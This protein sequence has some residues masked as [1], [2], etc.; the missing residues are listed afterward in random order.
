MQGRVTAGKTQLEERLLCTE[1]TV[2]GLGKLF[3][4]RVISGDKDSVVVQAE[5]CQGLSLGVAN[6]VFLLDYGH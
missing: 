2:G 1:G 6:S 3:N 4:R 5:D